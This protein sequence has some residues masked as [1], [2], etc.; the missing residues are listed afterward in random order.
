MA[1]IVRII[2]FKPVLRL[3]LLALAALC[4]SCANHSF[5][6]KWIGS[7]HLTKP[8]GT[9]DFMTQMAG[10]IELEIKAN[11]QFSL[12]EGGYPKSG[13]VRYADGK[14]YLK[15]ERLMDRPVAAHGEAAVAMNDEIVVEKSG[16]GAVTLFDPKGFDK[17]P[18]KLDKDAQPNGVPARK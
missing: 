3:A 8:D 6:G 16:N 14:A 2:A 4:V 10:K 7:R 5:E 9:T 13:S 1:D 17:E 15:I 11:G 18:I 12:Y